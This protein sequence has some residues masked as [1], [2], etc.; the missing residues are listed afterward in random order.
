MIRIR[1]RWVKQTLIVSRFPYG[2]VF[3]SDR[4]PK[5]LDIDMLLSCLF[6]QCDA[7]G[8]YIC[9]ED[10]GQGD[11][12]LMRDVFGVASQF[13]DEFLVLNAIMNFANIDE[14]DS[15][16]GL[17]KAAGVAVYLLR[18]VFDATACEAGALVRL[19]LCAARISK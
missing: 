10:S 18:N 16:T 1:A 12:R 2:V 11:V 9:H 15:P 13:T 3:I 5:R 6:G 7:D 17:L 14:V 4:W 8:W 19:N